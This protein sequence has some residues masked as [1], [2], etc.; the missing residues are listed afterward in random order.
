MDRGVL[1]EII[2]AAEIAPA[3]TVLE[4]GAGTGVLTEA[5]AR[6]A[7]RVIT[8]EIDRDLAQNLP[9]Y[10]NVQ[11]VEGDFLKEAE[12]IFAG[13][14]TKIKV[15]ANI[16]YYITT[17][18]IEK[19]LDYRAQITAITLMVQK[20]VADRICAAPGGRDYG[21]LS[22][23]L[24]YYAKVRLVCLVPSAAFRPRPQVDSAVVRLDIR[25]EPQY[26]PLSEKRFFNIVRGAFWGRRKTLRNTLKQSPYTHYTDAL[27]ARLAAATG[28]DLNRRGETLSIE[29]F[30]RLS[31][32]DWRA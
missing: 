27:L 9:G 3:D 32:V 18:L 14:K 25:S 10:P 21:S 22:V 12:N 19:L 26:R 17:P 6:R 15:I 31:D 20:E 7:G 23:F 2:T 30:G 28:I 24:Q 29:E 13:L 16:P 8:V 4:I 1:Q 5:L 11:L